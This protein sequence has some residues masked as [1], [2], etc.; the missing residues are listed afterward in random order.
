MKTGANGVRWKERSEKRL[1]WKICQDV[2]QPQ[3]TEIDC[4]IETVR[5]KV[6]RER[7]RE[8]EKKKERKRKREREIKSE[9]LPK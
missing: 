6:E 9:K 2:R 7:E 4:P 8:R 1:M 5:K 3:N